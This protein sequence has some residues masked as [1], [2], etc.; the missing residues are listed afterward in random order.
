MSMMKKTAIFSLVIV[1]GFIFNFGSAFEA[2]PSFLGSIFGSSEA[3]AATGFP[4][5]PGTDLKKDPPKK[6]KA[7]TPDDG[8]HHH[9]HGGSGCELDLDRATRL[10]KRGRTDRGL[11]IAHR[12]VH[13]L[14]DCIRGILD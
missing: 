6:Q 10:I 12:E 5:F 9:H 13:E 3:S 8:G 7:S 1:F 2:F 11:R 4:G 14:K